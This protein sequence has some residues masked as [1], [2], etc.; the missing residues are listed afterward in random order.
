MIGRYFVTRASLECNVCMRIERRLI[1]ET[2]VL[3]DEQGCDDVYIELLKSLCRGIK[4][5]QTND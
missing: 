5:K 4:K 3:Y 2:I 1:T